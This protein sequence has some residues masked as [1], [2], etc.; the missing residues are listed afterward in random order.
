M[1]PMVRSGQAGLTGQAGPMDSVGQ[2]RQMP[3]MIRSGQVRHRFRFY[4]SWRPRPQQ[5][6]AVVIVYPQDSYQS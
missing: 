1:A 2:M 6:F 3:P 5:V 4:L